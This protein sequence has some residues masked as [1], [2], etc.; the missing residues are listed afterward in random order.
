MQNIDVDVIKNNDGVYDIYF[1][2][3]DIGKIGG[4]DTAIKL[5][6]M[7]EKRALSSEM[8]RPE[9]RR[10]WWGNLF[11][12]YSGFEIG[13]KNWLLAQ[14]RAT[15]LTLNLAITYSQDALQWFIT[16]GFVSNIDVTGTL[17]NSEIAVDIKFLRG[18]SLV[19][20]YG[21]AIW[22]NTFVNKT[23]F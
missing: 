3:G 23:T 7:C 22:N 17:G 5:S 4:F 11:N 8:I 13:S 6:L 10:G 9:T 14:A 1:E 18:A 21:Y 15:Q 19:G 12:G 2:N 20:S 16:D